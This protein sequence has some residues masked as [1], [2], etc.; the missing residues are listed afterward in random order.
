MP[1]SKGRAGIGPDVGDFAGRGGR[2]DQP[3][4]GQ[5]AAESNPLRHRRS[6]LL[7]LPRQGRSVHP[8]RAAA[9]CGS[10]DPK[11]CCS[12]PMPVEQLRSRPDCPT[13]SVGSPGIAEEMGRRSR[14]SGCRGCRNDPLGVADE[15]NQDAHQ[16]HAAVADR[17]S[18]WRAMCGRSTRRSWS[19]SAASLA[20]VARPASGSRPDRPRRLLAPA[21]TATARRWPNSRIRR[22][23]TCG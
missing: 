19:S 23:T 21:T 2:G 6:D 11:G 9:A 12:T 10:S 18:H 7:A 22:T 14:A 8:G 13:G 17:K 15:G 5:L 1:G 20:T 16:G 3:D 4:P